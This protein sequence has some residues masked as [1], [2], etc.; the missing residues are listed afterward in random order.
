MRRVEPSVIAGEP[1]RGLLAGGV[2]RESN[3][4]SVLVDAVTRLVVQQLLQPSKPITWAAAVGTSAGSRVRSGRGTAM[5]R[6]G[7]VPRRV[8]SRSRC[9]RSA[10]PGRRSG[11]R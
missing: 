8:G 9:R 1:L 11:R 10:A 6:V 2:D 7:S 3:M 5:S 4:I